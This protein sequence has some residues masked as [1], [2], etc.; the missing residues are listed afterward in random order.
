VQCDNHG[1]AA[2]KRLAQGEVFDAVLMD[3]QMPGMDGL[4]ATRQIRER[5]QLRELT[6]IALTAGALA[7]ERRRALEAGMDDFLTKPL[8]PEALVRTLRRHIEARRGAP[9]P[10]RGS[11][12]QAAL[13]ADW[14][15]IEGI[16]A[17]GTAHRL[18]GDTALF[19]R[20]LARL[21]QSHD[22]DWVKGLAVLQADQVSAQLHKL[23]GSA[24][25][26]GAQR[27][28]ALAA[29]GEERLRGG[30]TSAELSALLGSLAE[31][32][33]ALHS[34]AE[35]WLGQPRATSGGLEEPPLPDAQAAFAELLSL[36]RRQDLEAGSVLQSLRRWLRE[37]GLHAEEVDAVERCV[38]ELD[39]EKAL[40]LLEARGLGS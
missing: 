38:D 6:V 29:E 10:V 35:A 12:V 36:L 34:A 28:Q 26:L 8:D 2:L 17:Q 9:L 37:Q 25:L 7:E 4:A 23:R 20:L 30:A 5:L 22:A 40:G 13:P 1:E 31:S 21:L 39:F 32:I 11:D 14:P 33:S 27:I 18:G 16:A 24:G 3:I 15:Q 19:H